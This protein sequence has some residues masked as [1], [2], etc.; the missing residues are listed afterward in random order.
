MNTSLPSR[1]H[2]LFTSLTRAPHH[3][4]PPRRRLH[5]AGG[6]AALAVVFSSVLSAGCVSTPP[7]ALQMTPMPHGSVTV[8]QRNSSGSFGTLQG[9]VAWTQ[10]RATWRGRDVVMFSSPVA[11]ASLHEGAG[12]A[13]VATLAPSG[14][15][16]HSYDPPLD[17]R[18]PLKV[19][20][21]WTSV[22]MVYDHMQNRSSPLIIQ[23][24][25]DGWGDVRVP[26]GTYKA[27]QVS[28]ITSLDER[29]TRWISPELGLGIVKRHVERSPAHPQGA[30]VLDAELISVKAPGAAPT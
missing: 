17:L 1:P 16:Y 3:A 6:A 20:E 14:A 28:W 7:Q 21:R 8:F 29:E 12:M 2:S 9:E 4:P 23:W 26:A 27:Y 5:R 15:P 25:V 22:H 19:G 24:Q 11:G 30:G 18:W 10:G 13:T